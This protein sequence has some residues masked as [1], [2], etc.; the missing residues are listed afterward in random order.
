MI[1]LLA[2]IALLCQNPGYET[3]NSRLQCQAWYLKCTKSTIGHDTGRLGKCVE[4]RLQ[5]A[6]Q[7]P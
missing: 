2:T 3:A 6:E 4:K 1:E 7:K 5:E